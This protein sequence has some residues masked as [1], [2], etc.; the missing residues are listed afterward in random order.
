ML[1]FSALQTG[2]TC[3]PTQGATLSELTIAAGGEPRAFGFDPV[4]RGYDVPVLNRVVT[5]KATGRDTDAT[6]EWSVAEATGVVGSGMRLELELELEPGRQMLF[7]TVRAAGREGS[8]SVELN[9]VDDERACIDNTD[10]EEG[11]ACSYVHPVG[12]FVG[13]LGG[14]IDMDQDCEGNA[15]PVCGC[16]GNTYPSRCDLLRSNIALAHDGECAC[17]SNAD[18]AN[19]EYCSAR[20]CHGPGHCVARPESCEPGDGPVL[21]CNG[22]E[23]ESE[24]RAAARGQRVLIAG[25]RDAPPSP[26]LFMYLGTRTGGDIELFAS[27]PG[28]LGA[29]RVNQP[30]EDARVFFAQWSPSG[31]DIAYSVLYDPNPYD[32]FHISPKIFFSFNSFSLVKFSRIVILSVAY[33]S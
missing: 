9:Y 13:G 32:I 16:D 27:R 7:L 6:I 20:S 25:G 23:Y 17:S 24:C 1:A 22:F 15:S 12:C 31:S 33:L 28:M 19:D 26:Y 30:L 4:V 18:C 5:I 11:K 2:I 21:G 14:C 3:A 10:C 8:Y 29:T